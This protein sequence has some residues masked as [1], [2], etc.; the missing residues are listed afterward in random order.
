ME[1]IFDRPD[2]VFSGKMGLQQQ[3]KEKAEEE[4]LAEYSQRLKQSMG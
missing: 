1:K 3:Q 2:V 4:S